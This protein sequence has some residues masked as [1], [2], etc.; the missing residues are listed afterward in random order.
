[1]YSDQSQKCP[2]AEQCD[3]APRSCEYC[4]PELH[5][6]CNFAS[7]LHSTEHSNH[8]AYM[9]HIYALPSHKPAGNFLLQIT[10]KGYIFTI[11]IIGKGII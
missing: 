9:Q 2:K 4:T 5:V 7:S 8:E 1:M 11:A 6:V 10:A 3:D